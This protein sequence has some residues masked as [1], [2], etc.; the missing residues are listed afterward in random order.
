MK[1]WSED[2]SARPRGTPRLPG[3]EFHPR[4]VG[5]NLHRLL[6]HSELHPPW[7]SPEEGELMQQ[8]RQKFRELGAERMS[9]VFLPFLAKLETAEVSVPYK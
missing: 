2:Y 3:H 4:E 1:V 5:E 8:D 7:F 6:P 9:A